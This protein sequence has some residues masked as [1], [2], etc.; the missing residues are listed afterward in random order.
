MKKFVLMVGILAAVCLTAAGTLY[1][2]KEKIFQTKIEQGLQSLSGVPVEVHGLLVQKKRGIGWD[3][4]VIKIERLEFKNPPGFGSE[5]LSVI[6][7]V[8]F[9]VH[10]A[11]LLQ[12]RW[13]I[14]KLAA[15]IRRTNLELNSKGTSNLSAIPILAERVMG[16]AS[17]AAQ[18]HPFFMVER[19][20][21]TF[22]ELQFRDFRSS[23]TSKP[24]LF[25]FESKV[26]VYNDVRD[27]GILLQAPALKMVYQIG[28]GSLGIH[29]G[30]IQDSINRYTGTNVP[31]QAS[32]GNK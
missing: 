9:K 17:S 25:D 24:V 14:E 7:R 12:Q 28:Q 13:H 20:E 1:F 2:N 30:K 31:P 23:K 27:P 21:L 26:E 29:R 10:L 11:A 18:A 19:L 3:V 15:T 16:T 4:V 22:R 6:E 32:V 5:T 8:A